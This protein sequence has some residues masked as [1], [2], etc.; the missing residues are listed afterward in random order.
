MAKPPSRGLG[1][2]GIEKRRGVN[3]HDFSWAY[4]ERTVDSSQARMANYYPVSRRGSNVLISGPSQ[5]IRSH[6]RCAVRE[7]DAQSMKGG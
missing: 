4:I 7:N 3:M 1:V 2:V 6:H 5:I